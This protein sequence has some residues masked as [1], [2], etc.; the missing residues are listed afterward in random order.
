[1]MLAALQ[2]PG[3][4]T[5]IGS[6]DPAA[7]TGPAAVDAVDTAGDP[8]GCWRSLDRRRRLTSGWAPALV[9]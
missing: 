5:R 2:D 3:P 9:D 6:A 4:M 8:D 1:M 7:L